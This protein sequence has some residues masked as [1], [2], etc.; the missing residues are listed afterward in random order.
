MT[1]IVEETKTDAHK[2]TTSSWHCGG[3]GRC[4]ASGLVGTVTVPHHV[5]VLRGHDVHVDALAAVGGRH[6][7]PQR[8]ELRVCRAAAR[9]ARAGDHLWRV[10]DCLRVR[11]GPLP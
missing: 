10:V 1:R 11:N 7:L 3:H 5:R 8:H 6:R 9:A 2:S 4:T